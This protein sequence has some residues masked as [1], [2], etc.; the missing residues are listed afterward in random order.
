[1]LFVSTYLIVLTC[2]FLGFVFWSRLNTYMFIL[3]Y[4][5][6]AFLDRGMSHFKHISIVRFHTFSLLHIKFLITVCCWWRSQQSSLSSISTNI[7]CICVP[8]STIGF[9]KKGFKNVKTKCIYRKLMYHFSNHQFILIHFGIVI[10][11][12]RQI[13][14]MVMN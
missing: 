9:L 13:C 14:R 8:L 4:L 12:T 5:F 7:I 3:I 11:I 6:Y 10:V 1:M 2:F